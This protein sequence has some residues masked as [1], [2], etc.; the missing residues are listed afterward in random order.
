[1]QAYH[2]FIAGGTGYVGRA[3]IPLLLARGHQVR[4]LI[5]SESQG[6]APSGCDV[7]IADPL[8]KTSFAP[9]VPPCD[10]FVQLVGVPHP[11]PTKAKFFR[12]IDLVSAQASI[13]AA[14]DAAVRHLFTS[15]WLNLRLS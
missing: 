15:A 14:V 11:S 10:T 9:R 3:L 7:V 5:R 1:M 2:V 4:A 8:V 12:S 6:K 13:A